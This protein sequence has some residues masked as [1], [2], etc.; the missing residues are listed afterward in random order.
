MT[1]ASLFREQAIDDNGRPVPG[2]LVS[3]RQGSRPGP[4]YLD[5]DLRTPA[6]NPYP[7]KAG[8][9]ITLYL[10]AGEQ[11]EVTITSPK[12]QVLDQF[13]R[14][15]EAI[16]IPEQPVPEPAPAPVADPEE[17]KAAIMRGLGKIEETGAKLKERPEAPEPEPEEVVPDEVKQA[18]KEAGIDW[19]DSR[20]AVSNALI[21]KYRYYKGA[22]EY[23]RTNGTFDGRGVIYWEKKAEGID[24]ATA[25]NRA[26][27]VETL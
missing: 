21:A 5:P 20:E 8:G 6:R 10:H 17:A 24:D 27:K 2:A 3:F 25:W 9:R 19:R 26:R 22:A 23:A 14:T 11:Y 16:A 12:G 18:L 4:I 1:Q 13:V 15:F 7:A